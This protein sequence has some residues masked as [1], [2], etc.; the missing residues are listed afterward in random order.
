MRVL[1]FFLSALFF[2]SCNSNAQ[3]KENKSY[4]VTKT[5]V[6]W[7]AQLTDMQYYILRQSGTERAFTHPLNKNYNKGSYYCAACNTILYESNDKFDSKTGWPSF[8]R[9]QNI[10]TDVDYKAGYARTELKCATC[11]G[12]LG[13]KFN[14]GPKETTGERHCINGAA[15]IFVAKKD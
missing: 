1:I 5:E 13:H 12:H 2:M 7:K 14:D 8:D 10:E 6:Q 11:G 3:K 15:L 4:V 9:G